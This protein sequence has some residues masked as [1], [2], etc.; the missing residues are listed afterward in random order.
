MSGAGNIGGN[1]ETL[2]PS[3]FEIWAARE[4]YDT[5]PAVLPCSLRQ[6]ADGTTQEAFRVW[7]A[8][9]AHT[10]RMVT[11]HAGD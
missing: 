11:E 9:A 1:A 8:S 2:P 4:G 3:P 5:A 6:Y 10:A 7:N